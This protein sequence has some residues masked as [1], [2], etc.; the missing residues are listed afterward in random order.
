MFLNLLGGLVVVGLAGV[1]TFFTLQA[2]TTKPTAPEPE[3]IK[4]VPASPTPVPSPAIRRATVTSPVNLRAGKSTASAIL[5]DVKGG[6]AVTLGPDHDD[7]WQ[8][9]EY[10]GTK[11]YIARTYLAY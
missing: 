4:S 2:S 7:L 8:E 10:K 6:D 9:V 5:A 1:L 11:G 3:V